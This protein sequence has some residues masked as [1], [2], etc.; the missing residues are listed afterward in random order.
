M[1]VT[2][3]EIEPTDDAWCPNHCRYKPCWQCRD[4]AKEFILEAIREEGVSDR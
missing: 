2:D 4:E 3:Y 1:S